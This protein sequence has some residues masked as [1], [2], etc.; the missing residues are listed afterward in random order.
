VAY[1]LLSPFAGSS[2]QVFTDFQEVARQWPLRQRLPH[3]LPGTLRVRWVP[4]HLNVPGNEAAD[5][6]AKAGAALPPP[7]RAICTQASLRRLAKAK[8]KDSLSRLWLTTAPQS[9]RDL[10]IYYSHDTTELGLNRGALGRILAA[11]SHHG[12]FAAY[13]E[14]F[15]HPDATLN[16]SCGRPKSPLHFFFCKKSNARRLGPKAP[17][18]DKITYLLGT[19]K[20]A[21]TL[22]SW[23]TSSRFFIDTCKPYHRLEDPL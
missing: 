9:Y 4:G 20:G 14:R 12:D 1:R 17:T 18:G 3:T 23:I 13:H 5:Q 19:A 16:C 8:A 11:R 21:S 10:G 7:P 15:H 22:A 2:Q 6:A